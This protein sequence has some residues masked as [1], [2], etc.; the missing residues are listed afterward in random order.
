LNLKRLG[1]F[2]FRDRAKWLAPRIW[3]SAQ[4]FVVE[5]AREALK[6]MAERATFRNTKSEIAFFAIALSYSA[7]HLRIYVAT[8]K[9]WLV[10]ALP[11]GEV[12]AHR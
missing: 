3:L 9:G 8:A 4:F 1:F 10:S 5:V 7:R 2:V 11:S 6:K 12:G